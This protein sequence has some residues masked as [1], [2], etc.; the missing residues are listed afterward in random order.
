M[1]YEPLTKYACKDLDCETEFV[2]KNQTLE[3]E[4]KMTCPICRDEAESVVGPVEDGD[5]FEFGQL[6]CLYPVG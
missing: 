5:S 3:T 4:S 1:V 6:G 2:M